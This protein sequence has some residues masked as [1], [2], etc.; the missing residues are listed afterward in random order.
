MD[1]SG[2][3]RAAVYGPVQ[4]I[5]DRQA[6]PDEYTDVRHSSCINCEQPY[7]PDMNVIFVQTREGLL[8]WHRHH[9]TA[10]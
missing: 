9:C 10:P 4:H 6:S 5:D 3:T 1:P 7:N 2:M 8:W